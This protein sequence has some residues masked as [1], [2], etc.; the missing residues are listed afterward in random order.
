MR[1]R[2]I[3]AD[4]A[5]A[6]LID[7]ERQRRARFHHAFFDSADMRVDIA[8]IF[9]RVG[10]F[11]T[12]AVGRHDAG[13]ADLAAGFTIERRL[14]EDDAPAPPLFHPLDSLPAA[15]NG[16]TPA[17]GALGLVAEK[18]GGAELPP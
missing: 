10:D 11:E 16:G 4:R 6:G 18:F 2:V 9:L 17:L 12:N 7:L 1:R 14:I 8:G 5:A 13:V 15:Q 3:F